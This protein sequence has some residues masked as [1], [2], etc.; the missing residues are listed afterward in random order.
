MKYEEIIARVKS[1]GGFDVDDPTVGGWVNQLHKEAVAAAQWMEA[2]IDLATTAEGVAA[3][4]VPDNVADLAS[5]WLEPGGKPGDWEI[6]GRTAL[7]ALK[8]GRSF[9]RGSG[10]VFARAFT[11]D[12]T[13]Q[14]ELFPVPAGETAGLA[15]KADVALIPGDMKAG[16]T[17]VIPAD[18]HGRLLEGSIAIGLARIDERPDS[19]QVFQQRMAEMAEMLRRRKNSRIGSE[20]TRIS[21]EGYDF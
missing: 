12:G 11:A 5:L 6:V 14:V 19:A 7:R 17:P 4:D 10:G 2:E 16:D 18:M 20:P 9:L 15:I 8:G 21:V 3:Y 1:E 13:H